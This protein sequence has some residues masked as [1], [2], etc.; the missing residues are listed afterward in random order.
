ML[1]S[2]LCHQ[3][4]FSQSNVAERRS[5]DGHDQSETQGRDH[6]HRSVVP[7]RVPSQLTLQGSQGQ[8]SDFSFHC[9]QEMRVSVETVLTGETGLRDGIDY[10]QVLSPSK[11]TNVEKRPP[12]QSLSPEV[13]VAFKT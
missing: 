9:Q 4:E 13:C 11:S 1:H 2:G 6:N 10:L 12:L 7:L 5:G 3:P 8:S